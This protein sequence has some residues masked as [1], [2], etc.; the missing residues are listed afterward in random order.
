MIFTKQIRSVKVLL[1]ATV[2]TNTVVAQSQSD[3]LR[4][5]FPDAE[6]IF[7]QHNLSLL[8]AK[9]NIDA[10]KALIKQAKLWDNPLLT[11]DQNVYDKQ[12]GFFKHDQNNGQFYVQVTQLIKTAGKRSKAVRLATDNAT[13]SAEQFDDMLRSLRYTLR[14]DLLE[15]NHLLKIKRVYDGEIEQVNKL[16]AGMDLQL[17]AGNVSVKDNL[18]I[19]ALLFSLQNEL[20]NVVA[21]LMPVENELKFLLNNNITGFIAPILEYKFGELT[22]VLVPSADDLLKQAMTIRPDEK[23][24]QTMVDLQ[25]HNLV[26][27]KALARPDV[28]IGTEFDQHSSYAPDYVGL[29]IAVPLNIFNHNQG[30]ITSAKF[31]I[32]QQKVL[33]DQTGFKIQQDI[34]AAV[35]KLKFYQG[36]NNSQQL[37]FS[38]KY[39]TLFFSMLK[40]YEDKQMNLL[41]F[42]DFMD[43]YK[44]TKL[45]LL[46]QHNGL[47]R[48]IEELNYVVGEDIVKLN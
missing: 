14:S 19:K 21:Q 7:L 43:A 36:V 47:V 1:L 28:S 18:R 20:V 6:K 41:D 17:Q 23:M 24:A 40:S 4:L 2:I 34:A 46:E 10:N 38:K 5:S 15:I 30:N 9:Y 25:N 42:I 39:D 31:A 48:S 3:T 35:E 45:K 44:D 22:T 16:V 37:D 8:A 13:L 12:G 26:Y 29:S 11:T 33:A 32:Q 27:Q